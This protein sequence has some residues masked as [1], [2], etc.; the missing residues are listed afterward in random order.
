VETTALRCSQL[1][2]LY[3]RLSNSRPAVVWW[4]FHSRMYPRNGG[5]RGS[6]QELFQE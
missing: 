2:A 1:E 3:Q 6:N 5:G 4:R